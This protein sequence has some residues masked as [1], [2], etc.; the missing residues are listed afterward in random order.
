MQEPCLSPVRGS[1]VADEAQQLASSTSC[2]IALA[3]VTASALSSW[4]DK[5]QKGLARCS[6][7]V[8]LLCR[9][10]GEAAKFEKAIEAA[11]AA[12][13]DE[14]LPQVISHCL[15]F[16]WHVSMLQQRGKPLL[17]CVRLASL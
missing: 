2:C 7:C 17:A 3:N 5:C 9:T 10:S 13:A 16:F 15:S 6:S 1:L 11:E 12:E 4:F 8:I 14:A